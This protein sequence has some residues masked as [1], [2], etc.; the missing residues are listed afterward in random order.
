MGNTHTKAD[1][2]DT[3]DPC[4][5]YL[6][7]KAYLLHMIPHH[8]VA[9]DMS[10]QVVQHTSNPYIKEIA[11]RIIWQ[12]TFENA[13]MGWHSHTA[14]DIGSDPIIARDRFDLTSM[15]FY[16]PD[17]SAP[18]PGYMCDPLFFDPDGHQ[19]KHG[20]HGHLSDKMFLEHMIPHHQVA[21][22]MSRR[23]LAHSSNPMLRGIANKIIRDQQLEIYTMNQ[24][25]DDEQRLNMEYPSI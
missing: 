2:I 20:Q 10:R 12:Q 8:Q 21:V 6:G 9:I 22:D 17:R 19:K 24:M 18:A 14:S 1:E 11:N 15:D 23:L 5:D 13:V 4:T 3:T 7:D 16:E 25:L